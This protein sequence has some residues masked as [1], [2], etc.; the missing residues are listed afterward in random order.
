M[1][2]LVVLYV[3]AT[4][5]HYPNNLQIQQPNNLAIKELESTNQCVHNLSSKH[6]LVKQNVCYFTLNLDV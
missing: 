4:S 6:S 5:I 1:H 3:C 2:D